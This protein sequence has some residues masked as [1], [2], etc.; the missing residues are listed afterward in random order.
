MRA[1]AVLPIPYHRLRPV[2]APSAV[3]EN[4]DDLAERLRLYQ[5]AVEIIADVVQRADDPDNPATDREG[6]WRTI[7]SV[8]ARSRCTPGRGPLTRFRGTLSP[9]LYPSPR[10]CGA[11]ACPG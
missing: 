8:S 3:A 7:Q 11:R 1:R 5:G 2:S 4:E 10:G 9:S 6:A